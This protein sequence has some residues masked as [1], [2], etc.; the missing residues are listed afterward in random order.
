MILVY[1]RSGGCVDDV[2]NDQT[3][4]QFTYVVVMHFMN[5]TGLCWII[6]TA[7]IMK[8]NFYLSAFD[9]LRINNKSGFRLANIFAQHKLLKL[10]LTRDN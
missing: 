8:I 9:W 6:R 1:F 10:F 5:G 7:A 2:F 3:N 4:H